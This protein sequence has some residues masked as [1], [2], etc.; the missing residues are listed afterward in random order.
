M[1]CTCN[2][3]KVFRLTE[4]TSFLSAARNCYTFEVDGD[5][6]KQQIVQAVLRI[7]GIRPLSVRTLVQKGKLKS[8][9]LSR[10]SKPA[11]IR[12][13]TVRKAFVSFRPGDKIEIL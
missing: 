12:R 2:T 13:P 8:Y 1:N 9:R 10:R 4:K 3:L 11:A 5:A 6:S 7:F